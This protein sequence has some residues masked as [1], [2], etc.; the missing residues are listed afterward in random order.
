MDLKIYI[1][2]GT[3][4]LSPSVEQGIDWT[5]ERKGVPGKLSF[6]AL[7][8]EILEAEEGNAV[9]AHVNGRTIFAG[10]IFR[11]S[12]NQDGKA[13]ITAYDQ[14]RYLKNKDTYV[15]GAATADEIIR[16]IAGDYGISLGEI[17]STGYTISS[18]IEDNA[19][20]IDMMQTA[21]DITLS[22]TRQMFILYDEAGKLTLKNAAD[23]HVGLMIDAETAQSYAAET[24][25]DSESYNR[26]KLVQT[27]KDGGIRKVFIAE[28]EANQ[29][30][31]GTLQLFETVNDA[32]NAQNRAEMLLELYNS[33]SKSLKISGV[34]GDLRVRA[35][36]FVIVQM[37]RA[38]VKLNNFMLVESCRH[39]FENELHTMDLS[40]KGGEFN[41]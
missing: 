34:L 38:G 15:F 25:I 31:W 29:Q 21:L 6:T 24:S 23:M 33:P 32:E 9:S 10:Y 37:D 5:T 11:I 26:V 8:D 17:A 1:Y 27:D 12:R 41:A 2:S 22:N 39:R 40:L 28:D 30:K 4:M 35:G 36:C 20:L 16:M 18:R 19:T 13:K 3:K 7:E 14:M